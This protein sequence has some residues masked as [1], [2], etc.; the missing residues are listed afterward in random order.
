LILQRGGLDFVAKLASEERNALLFL[1]EWAID[2]LSRIP[3]KLEAIY[4]AET[5]NHILSAIE[6]IKSRIF[7]VRNG[8]TDRRS[9]WLTAKERGDFKE[10]F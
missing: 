9:E 3:D 7:V 10:V 4:Y 1:A 8:M 6:N 5:K 2:E